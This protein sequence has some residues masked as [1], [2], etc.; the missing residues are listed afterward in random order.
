MRWLVR[1]LISACSVLPLV[2]EAMTWTTCQTVTSVSNYIAYNNSILFTV[3]PGV[4]G[5][6]YAGTPNGLAVAVGQLNVTSNNINSLLASLLVAASI[7]KGLMIYYD[8]SSSACYSEI[9]AIGGWGGQC[10]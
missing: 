1:F 2:C 8:S 6:T 5:C 10:P 3:S 4:S 7:G 9:V